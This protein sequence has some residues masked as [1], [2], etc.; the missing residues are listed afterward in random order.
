M[1]ALVKL[2]MVLQPY[3]RTKFED[4]L[5]SLNSKKQEEND[6]K[7][8]TANAHQTIESFDLETDMNMS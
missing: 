2:T 4:S 6:S 3:H 7:R 5:T 1:L 8:Q